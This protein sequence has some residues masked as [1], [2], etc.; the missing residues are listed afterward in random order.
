MSYA[1]SIIPSPLGDLIAM[2][3]ET[4]LVMLEFADSDNLGRKFAKVTESPF[5]I[6]TKK[7]SAQKTIE[8]MLRTSA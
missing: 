7:E 3:N 2:A 8:Q 5:V 4:Y 1:Q 6:L